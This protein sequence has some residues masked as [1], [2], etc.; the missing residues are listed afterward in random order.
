MCTMTGIYERFGRE[1]T[2]NESYRE[3]DFG[4]I[5]RK[6]RASPSSLD[7]ILLKE[8]GVDGRT[9]IGILRK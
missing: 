8:V 1:I 3:L 7:E 2:E 6:I 9:L 4:Q 5:C